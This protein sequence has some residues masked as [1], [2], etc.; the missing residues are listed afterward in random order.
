MLAF[1]VVVGNG[2]RKIKFEEKFFHCLLREGGG[3]RVANKQGR[4]FKL[5]VN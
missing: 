1:E 2:Y 4:D 5:I 3:F